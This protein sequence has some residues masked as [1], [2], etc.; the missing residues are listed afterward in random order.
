MR[1]G[2]GEPSGSGGGGSSK[3]G[4]DRGRGGTVAK[5]VLLEGGLVQ[6]LALRGAV[7]VVKVHAEAQLIAIL[8]EALEFV[9][10]T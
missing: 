6:A 3:G 7:P 5:E 10:A 1:V 8:F 9:A 2:R 4:L